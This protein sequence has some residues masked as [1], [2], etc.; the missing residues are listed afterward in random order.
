ML[1]AG[2]EGEAWCE[3]ARELAAEA[4]VPLDA[5]RIGHLD[6]DVYD[7]RCGWLRHRGD[8][9]RR[10][11]PGAPRPVHRL[12]TR[13]ASEDPQGALAAALGQILARSVDAPTG[14]TGVPA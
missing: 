9:T 4:N 7:P 5:F 3:A 11:D 10:R 1:I 8:R 14:V 2:E 6:G 13:D 12:A